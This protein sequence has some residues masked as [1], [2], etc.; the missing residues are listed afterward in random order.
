MGIRWKEGPRL[1]LGIISG[2]SIPLLKLYSLSPLALIS[3]PFSLSRF[4]GVGE[5]GEFK[6]SEERELAYGQVAASHRWLS[7]NRTSS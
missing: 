1:I 5:W 4:S 6:S 2:A 7:A 3:S